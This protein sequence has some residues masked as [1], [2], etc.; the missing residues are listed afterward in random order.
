IAMQETHL[1]N[2][3]AAEF[4]G[5]YQSWFKLVYSAHPENPCATAGVAFLLNKKW[6]DTENIRTY[7]LIPGRALMVS[8]PWHKGGVLNVLNIYAPNKPKER[9]NMWT[10]LWENW[11]RDIH[12]PLPTIILGDWNF[13]E[14]PRDRLSTKKT[15]G[16]RISPS[17]P[18]S[19]QRLKSL[20][21][22]EDG[23]RSTFPDSLEYTWT[24]PHATAQTATK[25]QP[26][27]RIDRIYVTHT[28][29]ES[30][31]NWSIEYTPIKSDHRLISVQLAY[32]SEI[33]PGHGRPN[34][35]LY[36]L[37]THKFI[38][39]ILRRGM[40]MQAEKVRL[41]AAERNSETNIQILWFKFKLEV[42]KY[43]R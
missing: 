11:R 33:K 31:R 2:G 10:K 16:L 8:I 41:E 42:M 35:S 43:A 14:D 37:N 38:R 36:L 7:D 12:L 39:E 9:D 4:E 18:A 21:K 22:M 6:I 34:L 23:W 13:V 24:Q 15:D 32:R 27:S 3:A 17:V 20:L 19:F 29:M 25:C 5:I 1:D 26:R 30:C 40:E 28:W